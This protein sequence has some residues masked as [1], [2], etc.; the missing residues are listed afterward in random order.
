MVP[1]CVRCNNTY[2]EL[3]EAAPIRNAAYR[4]YFVQCTAC[5]GVVGIQEFNNITAMLDKQNAALKKI[6]AVLNVH[7]D[8]D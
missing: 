3:I 1:T 8:L 4:L 6:A 5:G 2:F 7:V